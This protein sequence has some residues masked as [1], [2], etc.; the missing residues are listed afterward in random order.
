[1]GTDKDFC[2]FIVSTREGNFTTRVSFRRQRCGQK[3]GVVAVVAAA[4]AAKGFSSC[5]PRFFWKERPLAAAAAA[6]VAVVVVPNHF[7][8]R[9]PGSPDSV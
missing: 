2:T 7:S 1:M 9:A 3:T 4:V 5:A 6:A 8:A